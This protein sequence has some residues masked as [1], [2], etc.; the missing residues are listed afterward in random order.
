MLLQDHDS[1]I[2]SGE[3]QLDLLVLEKTEAR[4]KESAYKNKISKTLCL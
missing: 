1:L 2:L 4:I 3:K